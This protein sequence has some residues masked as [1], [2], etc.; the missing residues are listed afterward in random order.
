MYETY[1]AQRKAW[2]DENPLS[3]WREKNNMSLDDVAS[4]LGVSFSTVHRWE[5]GLTGLGE[6]HKQG[7]SGLLNLSLSKFEKTWNEWVQRKPV[8]KGVA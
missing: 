5:T 1:H 3:V 6:Q 2:R 7:L 4:A 8:L